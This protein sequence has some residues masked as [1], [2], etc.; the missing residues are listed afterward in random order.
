MLKS[1]R[2]KRKRKEDLPD[3]PEVKTLPFQSRGGT[4]SIPALGTKILGWETKIPSAAKKKKEGVK[5]G[6]KV[7]CLRQLT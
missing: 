4:G 2:Y 6:S 3:G 7:F 5:D 1:V